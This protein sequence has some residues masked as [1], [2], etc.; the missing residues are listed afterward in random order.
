VLPRRDDG[1]P[2]FWIESAPKKGAERVSNENP[3]TGSAGSKQPRA[4]DPEA[5]MQRVRRLARRR[6]AAAGAVRRC[7]A[8]LPAPTHRRFFYFCRRRSRT[9][10]PRPLRLRRLRR[11]PILRLRSPGTWSAQCADRPVQGKDRSDCDSSR[12]NC[13]AARRVS[14]LW[15]HPN[16]L[17]PRR[18]EP[19]PRRLAGEPQPVVRVGPCRDFRRRSGLMWCPLPPRGGLCPCRKPSASSPRSRSWRR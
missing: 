6:R 7:C 15:S 9:H 3:A 16:H 10:S 12:W 2:Q 8:C 18:A 11:L 4:N 5:M 14:A 19:S 13:V 17:N 1:D